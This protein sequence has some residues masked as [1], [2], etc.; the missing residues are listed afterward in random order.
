MRRT[1]RKA[2]VLM[3]AAAVGAA[4]L[5]PTALSARAD[6]SLASSVSTVTTTTLTMGTVTT[7]GQTVELAPMQ[8][9][10]QPANVPPTN[11][12]CD[13]DHGVPLIHAE[14]C[15]TPRPGDKEDGNHHC[16]GDMDADD[17]THCPPMGS[18]TPSGS[19]SGT[20]SS[21]ATPSGTASPSEDV[22]ENGGILG[23]TIAD[24]LVDAGVP[25]TEPED[26]GPISAPL[27][28]ALSPLDPIAAEVTCIVSLLGL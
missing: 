8:V 21:S 13:A 25:L 6:T 23:E 17:M 20:P 11:P 24:Q 9:N 15:E 7:T 18:P 14:V 3:G 5:L 16:D 19:P 4:L 10:S 12:P 26:S 22:C 28:S 2:R 27:E 1:H